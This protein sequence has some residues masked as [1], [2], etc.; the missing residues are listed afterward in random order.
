MDILKIKKYPEKVLRKRCES[1]HKMTEQIQNL[2]K[3]M[4]IT[5]RHFKGI[6]LAA[7]QVGINKRLIIA[8]MG[9]G[10]IALANPEIVESKGNDVLSEGCLSLPE[11]YVE[12][13]RCH[14]ILLTGIDE[15]GES[16]EIQAKGLMARVLQHEI[17]HLN[18]KLIIDYCPFWRKVKFNMKT[19]TFMR[20]NVLFDNYIHHKKIS[21]R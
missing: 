15:K 3:Q 2:F 21:C 20:F 14:E 5:M 10:L 11:V 7:P 1:V 18:G 4:F 12:V 8:D 19:L 16:I 17:D 13:E 6:G 9:E